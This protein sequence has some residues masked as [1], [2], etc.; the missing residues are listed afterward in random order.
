MPRLWK[1]I[2]NK[3]S[4]K[5]LSMWGRGWGEDYDR[6]AWST[7]VKPTAECSWNGSWIS[8]VSHETV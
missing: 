2:Y 7:K 4:A 6:T 3:S 5:M 1:G 8:R